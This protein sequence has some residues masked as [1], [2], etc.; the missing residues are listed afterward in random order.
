MRLEIASSLKELSVG[1][2]GQTKLSIIST[3]RS[4]PAMTGGGSGLDDLSIMH[5]VNSSCKTDSINIISKSLT[6][7]PL[8]TIISSP[9]IKPKKKLKKNDS[10]RSKMARSSVFL[11]NLFLQFAFKK[12]SFWCIKVQIRIKN[13]LEN[14]QITTINLLL[15][16]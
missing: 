13:D 5:R 8:M 15:R 7:A 1:G 4:L 16:T 9:F 6:I 3:F 2:G 11:K 10:K 14:W 12:C